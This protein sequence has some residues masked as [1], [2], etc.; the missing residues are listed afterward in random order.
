MPNQRKPRRGRPPGTAKADSK[1][2][3]ATV[4]LSPD[5]AA[6]L[7]R[8]QRRYS[9]TRSEAIRIMVGNELARERLI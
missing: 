3:A 4:K 8:Y 5:I 7:R 2:I 1:T 6:A 9:V